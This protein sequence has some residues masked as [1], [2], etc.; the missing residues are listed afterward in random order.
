MSREYILP[1]NGVTLANQAVTLLY[2]Q[3]MTAAPVVAVEPRRV[4]ISQ[5]SG[6]TSVQQRVQFVTQV[7]T[8]P[9]LTSQAPLKMKASDPVSL[10]TGGTAGAAGTSGINASAEG[11]GSKTVLMPTAFNQLNGFLWVAT[12]DDTYIETPQATPHGF[13][14][15][16]P[17]APSNLT[18]WNAFMIIKEIG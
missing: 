10:L 17:T 9:T 18:L 3:V 13:G 2:F 7:S 8:F 12:P 6:S 15:H 5:S 11:A 14:V 1:M 4:E 16:F